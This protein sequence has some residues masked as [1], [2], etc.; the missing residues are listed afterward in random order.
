MARP[1]TVSAA[2]DALCSQRI[3]SR[4]PAFLRLAEIIRSAGVRFVNLEGTLHHFEGSP[5]ATSGGTYVC[6]S[7]AILDDLQAL[8]FNLYAAANN[9]MVDWGEGG[10]LGTIATLERAGVVYAGIGRHLAEARTPRYLETPAG[11]VALIAVTST[12]PPGAHAGEQRPDCQG[13]P[14]VN[15]LRFETTIVVDRATLDTLAA[16]DRRLRLSAQREH[17]IQLGFQRP[18]PEGIT[19]LFGQRF[20]VGDPQGVR[21][22]P[23]AADLAGNLAW[24][25]DARRQAEWVVVSV[26]AHEQQ[27]GDNEQPAEFVPAFCRAA[28]EA[29]ADLVLGHGPHILRGMEIHRGRPIFYSLGNFIFQNETLWRQPQD[30]YERLGLPITATP[31]DLFDAR[32]ARGGFAA[33]PAY[34]E[35]VAPVVRVEGGP[36]PRLAEIR[37]YPVTLGYGLPRAQRGSPV[38]AGPDPGRAIIERMARLS[39]GCAIRWDDDGFG[40]V[41]L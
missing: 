8:G 23:H 36:S 2:G 34:W 4:E 15:P 13:R 33:D 1:L 10:L 3:A 27:N 41:A 20:R 39:P 38:L 37:L 6:G 32:G 29:G 18:D 21:T 19:T 24:I 17:S 28:V 40:A 14:G 30:F 22:Q 31:A 7:P 5:Q 9:H 25:R 12:M 11:R 16:I 35:S 26:H